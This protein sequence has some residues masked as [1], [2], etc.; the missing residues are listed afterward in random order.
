ME[1]RRTAVIKLETPED[2]DTHLRET[3]EQFKYCAN[4][5]SEWCWHGDDGYHVTSKAKAERGLYDQL[6]EDTELTANLVQKGIRQ[7]VESIKSGVERL[8][9]D[10]D[11][12]R[13]TF[14]ADT[15]IYDKRS[16]TFHRDHVSLSTPDGRIECDYILPDDADVPPTKYV[17]DEDYE[18]RRATLHQR[19][20]DW[21]L[22]AS[23]LKVGD[24]D[25]D[26]TTGHRTVLGVD[27]GVNQLAVAST[28]R[29]WSADEFNHWKREYEKR[30][31]AL[32]QCG[33]RAAHNAIA[34]VE[35]KED[36]RFEIFL[37]RVANEIVAEAVEHDCSHI[38][39]EDLTDIRENVP[40]A[41]WHHL[42]AF[43][44]LYEYVEYKAKEQGIKAVQVDP[45]NTSNRCSTCGFTHDD[46]RRG[47]NFECQECGYQ[48]HADYNASKN[49]GLQYLRRR[50]NADDGGAPVDVRLNRGT[51]NV[52]GEYDLP[53]SSEA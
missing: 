48:N 34:G 36:G 40:E 51:L 4:T 11:T 38:V 15:A 28:G 49:I 39:F 46:N 44:R 6:R 13:P 9:N 12:S 45:R 26:T 22:H 3:V 52:S 42:W 25:T 29:F 32:Q 20:G 41:S 50:Q 23:M 53:A 2:A 21:Y 31:G 37:H 27:L 30:R 43:R 5:A 24:D 17:T 10:Q 47:E 35:Q 8:K 18:F 1:Y 19:D 16:A 7:A 33:T 14:T